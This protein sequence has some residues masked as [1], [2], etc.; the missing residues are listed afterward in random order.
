[1]LILQ[2]KEKP[3]WV[4]AWCQWRSTS[5]VDTAASFQ[6]QQTTLSRSGSTTSICQ[7]VLASDFFATAEHCALLS[8]CPFSW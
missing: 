5:S 7:E 2:A 6:P 8:G 1:M 4:S 3:A